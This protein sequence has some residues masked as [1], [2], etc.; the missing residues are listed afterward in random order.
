MI[1]R[2][3]LPPAPLALALMAL[4][5]ALLFGACG[6]LIIEVNAPQ[7]R[8]FARRLDKDGYLGIM[9]RIDDVLNVAGHRLGTMEIESALVAHPRVAEAAVVGRQH[10]VKGES[11]F[12]FVVC[13]GERPSGD[14]SSLVAELRATVETLAPRVHVFGHIHEGYGQ[15]RERDTLYVNASC[16]DRRYRPVNAPIVVDLD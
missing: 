8:Y 10:E 5:Y 13:K 14:T 6:V 12:G 11:V 2:L 9:G 15:V 7:F 4:A 1:P 16:C 3:A